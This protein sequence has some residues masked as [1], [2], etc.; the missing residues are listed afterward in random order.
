[1]LTSTFTG[2]LYQTANSLVVSGWW[3]WTLPGSGLWWAML[4]GRE[5]QAARWMRLLFNGPWPTPS[6]LPACTDLGCLVLS[7]NGWWVTDMQQTCGRTAARPPQARSS[8]A[9]LRHQVV[10][11]DFPSVVCPQ[12]SSPSDWTASQSRPGNTYSWK[13]LVFLAIAGVGWSD[14]EPGI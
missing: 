8:T 12:V 14:T 7:S 2:C 9:S 5:G 10:R 11:L 13:T 4:D 6:S 1:M 3:L